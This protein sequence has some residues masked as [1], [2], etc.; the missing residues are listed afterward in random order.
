[1]G[2]SNNCFG[3]SGT[4]LQRSLN[5]WCACNWESSFLTH[6]GKG[7]FCDGVATQ[8]HGRPFSIL[9][10]VSLEM[11]AIFHQFKDYFAKRSMP[12]KQYKWCN[13]VL[14]KLRLKIKHFENL[15]Y[16]H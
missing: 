13:V 2:F 16:M 8:E 6:T 3:E 9:K 10:A 5:K 12:K 11:K 7:V 1:M 14:W 15:F 4:V